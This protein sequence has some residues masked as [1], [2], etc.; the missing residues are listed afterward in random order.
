D[1]EIEAYRKSDSEKARLKAK[2]DAYLAASGVTA[3]ASAGYCSLGRTEIE[4]G[5]QIGAVLRMN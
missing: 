3:G 4:K 5:S 1:A 2:R